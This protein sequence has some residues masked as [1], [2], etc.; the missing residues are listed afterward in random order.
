MLSP[1]CHFL[2]ASNL[3]SRPADVRHAAQRARQ[4][5]YRSPKSRRSGSGFWA[6]SLPLFGGTVILPHTVRAPLLQAAWPNPS[7]LGEKRWCCA[8]CESTSFINHLG[9]FSAPRCA[10]IS[11]DEAV[12]LSSP[13]STAVH[14]GLHQGV[15][16]FRPT[17]C[18]FTLC[19]GDRVLLVHSEERDAACRHRPAPPSTAFLR[20]PGVSF[21]AAKCPRPPAP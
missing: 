14:Q 10:L 18:V 20:V 17:V 9:G 1:A 21:S 8:L 3:S 5:S 2:I 4:H 19:R 12:P 16:S 11:C 6:R 15:G 13:W 7:I